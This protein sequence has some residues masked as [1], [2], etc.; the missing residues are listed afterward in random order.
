MISR[1]AALLAWLAISAN[2]RLTAAGYVRSLGGKTAPRDVVSQVPP[3]F[4]FNMDLTRQ[5]PAPGHVA[6]QLER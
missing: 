4:A 1:W 3:T 5:S 2:A 6:C